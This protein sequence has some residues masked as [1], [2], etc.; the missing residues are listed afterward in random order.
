M[1]TTQEL[2]LAATQRDP[3]GLDVREVPL[4]PPREKCF[5]GIELERASCR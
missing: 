3:K 2:R 1:K 4:L 5:V